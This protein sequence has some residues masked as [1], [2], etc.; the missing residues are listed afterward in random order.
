MQLW[1]K[2]GN[3]WDQ[4]QKRRHHFQKLPQGWFSPQGHWEKF[5]Q[6][7]KCVWEPS[8]TG[9]LLILIR[10]TR[11]QDQDSNPTQEQNDIK[12]FCHKVG[13]TS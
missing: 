13:K 10:Q 7:L 12:I 1:W 9:K 11:T 4:N 2:I 8:R 5:R 3:S 6:H